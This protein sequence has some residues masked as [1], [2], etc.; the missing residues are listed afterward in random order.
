MALAPRAVVGERDLE[1]GVHGLGPGIA[2]EDAIEAGRRDLRD[3]RRRAELA[4]VPHLE[5][6][7]VIE[8]PGLPPYRLDDPGPAMARVHAPQPGGAVEDLAAVFGGVMHVLRRHEYAR[9]GL[10]LAVRGKRHPESFEIVVARVHGRTGRKELTEGTL[11]HGTPPSMPRG[12]RQSGHASIEAMS[13][14]APW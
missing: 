2:E 8:R 6:R 9:R 3:Q 10:E 7:R 1:R 13:A 12:A 11:C 5:E 14:G 4:G